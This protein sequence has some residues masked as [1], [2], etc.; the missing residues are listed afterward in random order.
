MC[1]GSPITAAH[2]L[3]RH[4][5]FKCW[6]WIMVK[7]QWVLFL[8]VCSLK[9]LCQICWQLQR[10]EPLTSDCF[11]KKIQ[12]GKLELLI[13]QYIVFLYLFV[14]VKKISLPPAYT[15]T[16]NGKIF[17]RKSESPSAGKDLKHSVPLTS[18]RPGNV[19]SESQQVSCCLNRLPDCTKLHW[20]NKC[21]QNPFRYSMCGF[22]FL[23][24]NVIHTH[25]NS[26]IKT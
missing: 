9:S 23:K 20:R 16:V 6:S 4:A 11:L 8:H 12:D 24:C 3:W 15:P 17:L 21:K 18:F 14:L 10:Q 1:P 22:T 5:S 26:S 2:C 19:P 25:C 13:S 7:S